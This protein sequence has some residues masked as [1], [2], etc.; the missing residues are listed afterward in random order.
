[1]RTMHQTA[2]AQLLA[3]PVLAEW[4][5]E[6]L[7]TI[8]AGFLNVSDRSLTPSGGMDSERVGVKPAVGQVDQIHGDADASAKMTARDLTEKLETLRKQDR[9]EEVLATC[10]EMARRFGDSEEPAV[11]EAVAKAFFNKAAV[12]GMS[13]RFEEALAASDEMARRFGDSEAPTVQEAVAKAF[14]NKAAILSMSNRFEE[15][16]VAS[17]EV[18]RRF[19][20]SEEPAVQEAVAKALSDKVTVFYEL[21][22]SGKKRWPHPTRWRAASGTARS[23]PFKRESRK[24]LPTRR[25]CS[26]CRTGLRKCWPHPTRWRA[27]SGAARCCPFR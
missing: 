23:R 12:L 6:L 11:Q 13:N 15:A 17:D 5:G 24:P 16:L 20:D 1:M 4:R 27:A 25:R 21:K 9:P 14:V 3:S 26:A 22:S 7:A 18:A 2:F 19:G 10:D 8:P